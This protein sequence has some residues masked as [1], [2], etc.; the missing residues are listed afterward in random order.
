MITED[1]A[2]ITIQKN[3]ASEHKLCT[4]LIINMWMCSF[5]APSKAD[6]VIAR[7]KMSGLTV[8][9]VFSEIHNIKNLAT[10]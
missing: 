4:K 3:V 5:S 8:L 7:V 10:H 9:T 6:F 2:K 1:S